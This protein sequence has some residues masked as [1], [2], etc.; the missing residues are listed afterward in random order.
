MRA[1]PGPERI[2]KLR[3]CRKQRDIGTL[4]ADLAQVR[5]YSQYG[6]TSEGGAKI[7][8]HCECVSCRVVLYAV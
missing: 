2:P 3:S 7:Q 4:V 8:G 5:R 1:P 6:Y